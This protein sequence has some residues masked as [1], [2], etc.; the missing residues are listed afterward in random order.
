[1]LAS[2]IAMLV[3]LILGGMPLS[4]SRMARATV[5]AEE[6]QTHVRRTMKNQ[7]LGIRNAR[8]VSVSESGLEL[9]IQRPDGGLDIW[10]FDEGELVL[11]RQRPDLPPESDVMLRDV[12]E[13]S[14]FRLIS[15]TVPPHLADAHARARLHSD[16]WRYPRTA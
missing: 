14:M 6:L 13:R 11:D 10:Y 4:Y 12:T 1:M 9:R 5:L 3:G 15:Q 8:G 2:A 7:S 16:G